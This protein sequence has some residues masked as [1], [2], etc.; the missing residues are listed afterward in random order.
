MRRQLMI[1]FVFGIAVGAFCCVCVLG[2]VVLEL[3]VH[4]LVRFVSQLFPAYFAIVFRVEQVQHLY[5]SFAVC[6]QQHYFTFH[7]K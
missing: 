3:H 1:R 4:D 2:F 7:L 5:D 6:V